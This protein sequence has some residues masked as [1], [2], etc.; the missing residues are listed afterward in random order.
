MFG[1]PVISSAIIDRIAHHCHIIPI[2]GNSYR[3]KD[4]LHRD[5]KGGQN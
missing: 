5:Y 4:K 1:D 2:N 3:T